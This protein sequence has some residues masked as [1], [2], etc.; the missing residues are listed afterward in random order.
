MSKYLTNTS[1]SRT[2]NAKEASW[3]SVIYQ[4]GKPVLDSELNLSQDISAEKIEQTPSGFLSSQA[5]LNP[6]LD[7]SFEPPYL[8]PRESVAPTMTNSFAMRNLDARVAGLDLKVADTGAVGHN[9]IQLE[10]ASVGGGGIKRTDF[11][12]LEVWKAQVKPSVRARGFIEVVDIAGISDGDTIEIGGDTYTARASATGVAFDFVV[13][14]NPAVCAGNLANEINTSASDY[15]A[16][17]VGSRITIL[18]NDLGTLGNAIALV[19]SIDPSFLILS[20]ATLEGGVDGTN[21]PTNDTLYRYGNVNVESSLRL[22]DDIVDDFIG[23][24]STQRIQAQYRIR[25]TG[26]SEALNFK[27][28]PDGFSSAQLFAQGAQSSAVNDYPFV[29]ADRVSS[30]LNSDASQYAHKDAGLFV[31]G[32][33]SE[34]SANALGSVDGFVYAIPIGWVFRRNDSENTGFNPYTDTN[35]ALSWS[36]IDMNNPS[37]GF[38]PEGLSDRPDNKFHDLIDETDFLDCRRHILPYLDT[39]ALIKQN[40]HLLMDGE[41]STWA[42]DSGEKNLLGSGK[43]DFSSEL[44]V[45]NQIGRDDT[46]GGFGDATGSGRIIRNFDH[47]ARRFSDAPVVERVVFE[48]TPG[49]RSNAVDFG[50]IQLNLLNKGEA[51]EHA[52]SINEGKY[53]EK[54]TY[55]AGVESIFWYDGD[56]LILDLDKIDP[57]TNTN[58]TDNGQGL[59]FNTLAPSGVKITNVVGVYHNE[60]KEKDNLNVEAHVKSINGI[61]SQRLEVELGSNFAVANAGGLYADGSAKADYILVGGLDNGGLPVDAGSDMRIFLEVEI[62]YPQGYG[63]TDTPYR[64]LEA[65]SFASSGSDEVYRGVADKETDSKVVPFVEFDTTERP[66]DSV[67]VARLRLREGFREVSLNQ[68]G[69]R[70]DGGLLVPFREVLIPSFD[71]VAKVYT[72]KTSRRVFFNGDSTYRPKLTDSLSGASIYPNLVLTSDTPYN[73][74]ERVLYFTDEG[75]GGDYDYSIPIFVHYY[76]LDPVPNAGARG[77]QVSFYYGSKAPQT[78]GAKGGVILESGGGA[79]P[80]NL[81]LSVLDY[82]ENIWCGTTGKGSLGLPSPYPNPFDLIPIRDSLASTSYFGD[83][84]FDGDTLINLV[85]GSYNIG[86]V[87]LP[88]VSAPVFKTGTD[89]TGRFAQKHFYLELNDPLTDAEGR[90]YYDNISIMGRNR[91]SDT[92]R[93]SL[94]AGAQPLAYYKPHRNAL[95]ALVTPHQDYEQMRA[96]ELYLLV[97]CQ[98]G[99]GIENKV[100]YPLDPSDDSNRVS[101]SLYRIQ[102][103]PLVSKREVN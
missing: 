33:G 62:S 55:G 22:A 40:A 74:S 14:S 41:L 61:G 72:L 3:V 9:L 24:E 64:L 15:T 29:P 59:L 76:S 89:Y 90:V 102:G 101:A 47:I 34:A 16:S 4:S 10:P 31:A 70:I 39:G 96:G 82:E 99:E 17:A 91:F 35:A 50:G 23:V 94:F 26:E 30:N 95:Y 103:N 100:Q 37:I 18:A 56:K 84:G 28:S 77:Y 81:G 80:A 51:P 65:S 79:L 21:K 88:L 52:P 44:L 86:L 43:G 97:L 58:W 66:E 27:T 83:W 12:F 73:S 2:L 13:G 32:D 67:G 20:G 46:L 48:Y 57:S 60:G 36:H 7:F 71:P 78:Y 42:M 69:G 53:V 38:I 1:V 87:K 68:V 45:C 6:L 75:A 19:T 8:G 49:D 54:A 11:V 85:S 93:Y 92:Q 5:D 98:W 63:L 25:V